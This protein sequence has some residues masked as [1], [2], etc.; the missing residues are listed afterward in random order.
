MFNYNHLF[1]FYTVVKEGGISAAARKLSISQPALSAQ[2]RQL[3]KFMGKKLFQREGKGIRPTEFGLM[4]FS[5]TQKMFETAFEL[6]EQLNKRG[7]SKGQVYQIGVSDDLER[8]WV[9]ELVAGLSSSQDRFRLPQPAYISGPH[10]ALETKLRKKSLD[11]VFSHTPV[12]DD[13]LVTAASLEIPVMLGVPSTLVLGDA[14]VALLA[15]G[16]LDPVFQ[17]DGWGLAIPS[18]SFRLRDETEKYLKSGRKVPRIVFEGEVLSAVTMAVETQQ[19]AAFLPAPY[20]SKGA[21]EGSLKICGPAAGFWRHKVFL[22]TTKTGLQ[23]PFF[24]ELVAGVARIKKTM[25][26]AA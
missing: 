6:M 19:G 17:D 7:E 18:R 9:S 13:D 11:V 25:E 23:N 22:I 14:E 24:T 26:Q 2:I 16:Q 1:Y 15:I 5:H 12:D 4:V 3:E 20:L 10:E 8:A 21:G